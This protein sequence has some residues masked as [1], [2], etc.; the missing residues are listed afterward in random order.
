MDAMSDTLFDTCRR[1]NVKSRNETTLMEETF[2][3]RRRF[4]THNVDKGDQDF[5]MLV[6]Y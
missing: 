6:A 3:I 5:D 4:P 1:L 2:D